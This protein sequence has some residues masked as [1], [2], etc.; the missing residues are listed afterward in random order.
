MCRH[1]DVMGIFFFIVE[2][3]G[4]FVEL[5]MTLLR[6]RPRRK[7]RCG[8]AEV[9][10]TSQGLVYVL[11]FAHKFHY[12]KRRFSSHQNIDTCMEY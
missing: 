12:A 9:Q 1:F 7:G 6:V 8:R 5:N 10:A 3:R 11:E 4:K 2:F